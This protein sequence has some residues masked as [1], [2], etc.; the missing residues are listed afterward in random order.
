VRTGSWS[1]GETV[2][3]NYGQEDGKATG[4]IR[5]KQAADASAESLEAAVQETVE[6]G[7][8]NTVTSKSTPICHSRKRSASG[9]LLQTKKDSG[10]AGMTDE[11][12]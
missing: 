8:E 3:C 6:P 9:I 11:K 4:R 7:D 5:L 10:Q 12:Y 1:R 2:G